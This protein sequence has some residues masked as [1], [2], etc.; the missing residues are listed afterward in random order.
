MRVATR[1]CSL[2][3]MGLLLL[4]T[5]GC[6]DLA[7]ENFTEPD[8]ERAL[9]D[10][11][12]LEELVAGAFNSW[13][14]SQSQSAGMGNSLSGLAMQHSQ[15]AGN[16]AFG[17][18]HQIP[19]PVL[20]NDP[21]ATEYSNLAHN[22]EWNYRAL[23]SIAI[24]LQAIAE[25]APLPPAEE[26]RLN[27]FAKFVQGLS[28]G[29]VALLYD[30]AFI[31]DETVE[32]ATT[33]QLQP[34]A[35]V[36]EAAFGFFD[37]AI[38]LASQ[39]NFTIPSLW[40]S[41]QT[42]SDELVGII[43]AYKARF[44]IGMARDPSERE[45][46]DWNAVL[47]D[48]D[49]AMDGDFVMQIGGAF[50][51]QVLFNGARC[52]WSQQQNWLRGMADQSG[53]YQEWASTYPITDRTPFVWVTPDQRFPQGS[54]LDEQRENPGM[55]II[56]PGT[57]GMT[58][59]LGDHFNGPAGGTWRWSNYR[60]DR[61]DGW[62][63]AGSTGPA[64][65]ISQRELQLYRAEAYLRQG[66]EEAAAAIIDE[67]RTTH[68]GLSSALENSECVPRMP[69]GSCGDIWEALKWEVRLETY[70]MGYGKAFWDAR[71]WGDLIEGTLL[72][73]P[74]PSRE[75]TFQNLPS[76]TFGGGEP[77][78]APVGTYGFP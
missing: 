4:G 6:M 37:E 18:L 42:T 61:H 35:E 40:M 13:W 14:T 36:M 54:T 63:G 38:A 78:S 51:H 30:Q 19:R 47:S 12:D 56:V 39:S 21:T 70:Q 32:D 58:C 50:G 65:E 67:T 60:D 44:R 77:S 17:F 2:L 7:V 74:V 69:D 23:S 62:L 52:R 49:Q 1:T 45:A 41:R 55:Y 3:G 72:E 8:R 22:W 43:H 25:G 27:A 76:Y 5:I 48:L 57:R 31:M 46:I 66:A 33:L 26:L 24:G 11:G 15:W 75:L 16:F 34:S 20:P 71:G 9:A 28:H 59:S 68:G 64:V 73:V 10:T 29:T 53:A